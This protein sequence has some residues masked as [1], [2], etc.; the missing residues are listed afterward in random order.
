MNIANLHECFLAS[1]GISTD[2][3]KIKPGVLF[4][5]LKG[6][7]F[8]GN[9]FAKKAL[10]Q[11]AI[12]VVVDEPILDPS[13]KVF[14][15]NDV[16]TCL[17]KLANFHR[18]LFDIPVIAIT[19]TNGKTT[20]KE[21][22]FAS[23]HNSKKTLC[24]EGNLNNHIGVPL[25]LLKITVDHEFVIIE[26][27]ANKLGDI[28]ELCDIANP[29]AGLITN[30]GKA[31]LGGFGD[32]EGV[33]KTKTELY[34]FLH[35]KSGTV[36]VDENDTIL[37]QNLRPLS[38]VRTFTV[39]QSEKSS[40]HFHFETIENTKNLAEIKHLDTTIKS[41]LIG[42]YNNNNIAAAITISLEHG[43]NIND[44]KKGIEAYIPTN[45]RSEFQVSSDNHIIWDAYNANPSSVGLAL[46]NLI[47]LKSELQ[48][49][50]ILGDMNEL[51]D[52]AEEEHKEVISLVSS[53]DIKAF[54]VGPQFGKLASTL[55]FIL[56]EDLM[57]Y[58]TKNQIRN[59]LILIKGSR[60][61]QLEKLR[62]LFE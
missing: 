14:Q 58:L 32:F 5:A 62:S 7:N 28:S 15:V 11:G 48:K 34:A 40:K 20:T 25:T 21:L 36:F 51:G 44:I 12:A 19:G 13:G 29:T 49:V 39:G 1:N 54:Y 2:T 45:N 30:V 59:S 35:K 31:H 47:Q 4:F 57:V 60:S 3:R 50:A 53:N 9:T 10:K 37:I 18:N 17:Q 43:I 6:A 33:V 8:N 46:Q 61:I 26:M 52:Y 23:M 56:A 24:T 42:N 22:L 27:G 38:H 41:K 55:H 16:L